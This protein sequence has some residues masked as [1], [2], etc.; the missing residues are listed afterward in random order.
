VATGGHGNRRDAPQSLTTLSPVRPD[1]LSDLRRRL[2]FVSSVPGVGRPLLE[3]GTVQYARWLVFSHLPSPDGTGHKWRL[4]WTYLLFDATY[5]GSREQYVRAFADIL[6]LRL[7]KLFGTC[8]GFETY[9]EKAH[10]SDARVVPAA[11]FD[12]YLATNTL[13]MRDGHFWRARPDSVATIRQALAIERVTRRGDR[14]RDA[15]SRTEH[16]IA[17]LALGPPATRPTFGEAALQP[18]RRRLRPSSAVNPLVLAI[19]VEKDIWEWLCLGPLPR[20][21][22][23]RV[24]GIPAT[25]QQHLGHPD[26]DRLEC[27]YLMFSFDHDGTFEDYLTELEDPELAIHDLFRCC[28]RYPGV[29]DRFKFRRWIRRHRLEV[30]Y[31]LAGVPPRPVDKVGE[32]VKDRELIAEVMLNGTAGLTEDAP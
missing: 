6:P 27:D 23:A 25:M 29:G 30:Q 20:T 28:A 4:N 31:F 32:L 18:W 15:L 24:V 8:F 10:G 1:R 5:D 9:V 13:R 22:F 19:P 7:T 21:H 12:R 17:A 26:P 16:E 2:W 14:R 11:A 3:L